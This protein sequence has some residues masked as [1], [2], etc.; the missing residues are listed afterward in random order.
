MSSIH[1]LDK[2]YGLTKIFYFMVMVRQASESRRE[3]GAR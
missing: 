1:K 2:I 3:V